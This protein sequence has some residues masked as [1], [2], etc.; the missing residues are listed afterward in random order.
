MRVLLEEVVLD[1]PDVVEA[2]AVGE[3]DLIQ[4]VL[5]QPMLAVGLP[6]AWQLVLVEAV[7]SASRRSIPT[8]GSRS[9]V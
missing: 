7:R 2:D 5:E 1:L 3:L 9:W 8:V 4:R 6:R